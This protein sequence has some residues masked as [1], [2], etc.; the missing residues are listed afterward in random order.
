[1]NLPLTK[2]PGGLGGLY[3]GEGDGAGEG[4]GEVEGVGDGEA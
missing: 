3:K 1:M 4:F 2:L